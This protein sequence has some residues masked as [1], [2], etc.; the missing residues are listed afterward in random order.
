MSTG[1]IAYLAM[2]LAAVVTFIGVVGG[3]SVWSRGASKK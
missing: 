2:V 1:E 3:V